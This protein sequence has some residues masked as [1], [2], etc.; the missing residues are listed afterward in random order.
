MEDEHTVTA[1]RKATRKKQEVQFAERVGLKIEDTRWALALPRAKLT[2]PP[3][4]P[5]VPK[6]LTMIVKPID[7]S[8]KQNNKKSGK[9]CMIVLQPLTLLKRVNA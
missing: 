7:S 8:A 5:P 6:T 3:E 2:A 1:G 4:T 9:A